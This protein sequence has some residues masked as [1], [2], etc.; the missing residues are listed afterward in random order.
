MN[1]ENY[2]KKNKELIAKM[3]K[4][5]K[6]ILNSLE[7]N[8]KS[9]MLEKQRA[10]SQMIEKENSAREKVRKYLEFQENERLK[11]EQSTLEKRKNIFFLIFF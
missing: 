9:K 8:R 4:R 10:I 11:F 6:L 7:N 2:Q 3:K 1:E 5:E